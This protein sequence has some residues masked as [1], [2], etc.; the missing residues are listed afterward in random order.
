MTPNSISQDEIKRL[1]DYHPDG[2][3]TWKIKPHDRIS[4]GD[5]VGSLHTTGYIVTGYKYKSYAV[6]RL[7]WAWHHKK[8]YWKINHIN[9][10]KTDNRIENLTP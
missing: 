2:Y 9:G 8:Q 4:I 1:F 10:I 7:I 6:H 5:K 3:L